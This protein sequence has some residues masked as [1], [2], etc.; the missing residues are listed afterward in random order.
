[1]VLLLYILSMSIFANPGR[2][3]PHWLSARRLNPTLK[4]CSAFALATHL[5][6]PVAEAPTSVMFVAS[7][8]AVG[9]TL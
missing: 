7:S 9:A 6:H 5:V 2:Q 4:R 8:V 1:M 3:L